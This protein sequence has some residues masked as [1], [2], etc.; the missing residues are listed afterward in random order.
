MPCRDGTGW[1]GRAYQILLIDRALG[2]AG[3]EAEQPKDGKRINLT[4]RFN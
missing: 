4:R 1:L 3:S 2:V